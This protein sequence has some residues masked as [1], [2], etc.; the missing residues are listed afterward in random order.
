MPTLPAKSQQ[1]LV[2][3]TGLIH[4]VVTACHNRDTLP[5]LEQILK[6]SEENGWAQLVAV[7]RRIL[8]G[9][10]DP[11]LLNGLDEEDGLII[12]AIL[13]GLQNPATMPDLNATADP[14]HAAPGLA[15]MVAAARRGDVEALQALANMAIQ[16]KQAGGDM[17]KIAAVLSRL[18]QGERDADLLCEGLSP[19]G[20]KLVQ[21]I[22]EEL[23]KLE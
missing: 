12:G 18:D 2:S 9:R 13:N 11:S 8:A 16:M 5:Q 4:A 6:L 14:N 15:S 1:I 22:L 20:Q 7:I 3:H 23:E 19:P 17:G 10:R 21:S